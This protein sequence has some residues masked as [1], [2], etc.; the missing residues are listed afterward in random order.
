MTRIPNGRDLAFAVRDADGVVWL[1]T[2][3]SELDEQVIWTRFEFGAP[4]K[5]AH[6]RYHWARAQKDRGASI[7]VVRCEVVG[8]VDLEAMT[9]ADALQD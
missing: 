1:H 9:E 4:M 8:E 5:D 2:M 3:T 7:V 6:E